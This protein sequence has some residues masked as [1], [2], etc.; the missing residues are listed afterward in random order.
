[1]CSSDLEDLF[2]LTEEQALKNVEGIIAND[3][4][5]KQTMIVLF[6]GEPT[7]NWEVCKKAAIH[8][9][10]I[11]RDIFFCLSTNGW[12]FRHDDFCKDYLKFI[13]KINRQISID[14]SFDGVGN[15]RRKL[16]SGGD[17]TKGMY[18]VFKNIHR[19][20]LRYSLRYTVHNGNVEFAAKD[21]A[22]FNKFFN[23][24][25]YVLSFDD[26]FVA[27]DV[28]NKAKNDIRQEYIKGNITRPCCD[29][30]CDLCQKCDKSGGYSYWA[31][32]GNIRN[33]AEG[34]NA[35]VFKD[36]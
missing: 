3:D 12:K 2:D 26:S 11:K 31:E 22:N 36:F 8:A 15:F 14:L 10:N 32:D 23:P 5:G 13:Q 33:L 27:A 1:M 18:Q 17:T 35:S 29:V 6:G 20:Q 30:V 21:L 16:L 19:Y 25:K 7:L 24:E 4:P 9:Y 34:E 28:L